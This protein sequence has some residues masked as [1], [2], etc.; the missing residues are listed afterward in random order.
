MASSSLQSIKAITFD[1]DGTL[2]DFEAVMRKSLVLALE[3]LAEHDPVAASRLDVERVIAVRDRVAEELKSSVINLERVRLEGFKQVLADVGR[4]NDDLAD[5]INKTYLKYRYS[6]IVPYEDVIPTLTALREG[7]KIGALTNGNSYPERVGMGHVFDFS[8]LASEQGVSK[9]DP[10]IFHIAAEM[11]G[12]EPA[13]LLHVGDDL[14]DDIQG[15]TAAG[16]RAVWINRS[17][18]THSPEISPEFQIS[19]LSVLVNW[20]IE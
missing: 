9:P 12:C 4:R 5:H 13:E 6:N 15:A 18:N 16:V 17:G 14:V 10:R 1:L 20:L 3:E 7:Y 8:V 19:S 11:A 2:W